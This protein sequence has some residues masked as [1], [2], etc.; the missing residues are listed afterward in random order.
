MPQKRSKKTDIDKLRKI[1]DNP[2]DPNLKRDISEDDKSLGSIKQRLTET[3]DRKHAKS[4]S[5]YSSLKSD[6][7]EP[8]AIVYSK[9]KETSKPIPEEKI[10]EEQETEAKEESLQDLVD[11]EDLYEIEKVEEVED[12]G[13]EFI[14]V[15]SKELETQELPFKENDR[16]VESFEQRNKYST[17]ETPSKEEALPE[18]KQV[19]EPTTNENEQKPEDVPDFTLVEKQKTDVYKEKQEAIPTWEPIEHESIEEKAKIPEMLEEKPFNAKEKIF[20]DIKSIDE[21]TA[22]LLY[23][24][25]YTSIDAIKKA[26]IKNL[27][28]IKGINRKFAKNIKAE[29]DE[30]TEWES[31]HVDELDEIPQ[32][33]SKYTHGQY[34][35]YRK[36]IITATGKKRTIHFFSKKIPDEGKPVPLP[37]GY[38][39]KVN[40]RTGLP[41]LK[42]K[43]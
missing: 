41:Y 22:T 32:E 38:E 40:K 11:V 39:V 20:K 13:Q 28:K 43:T 25:G 37:E 31:Y 10:I 42:K 27:S 35:L 5:D 34:T 9:E 14:E 6:S 19:E 36:E 24:N 15:K 3:S 2:Y 18:W 8:K 26:T 16:G 33:K 30:F 7:L 23:N 17:E 1:L 12:T 29:C 4:S 21:K